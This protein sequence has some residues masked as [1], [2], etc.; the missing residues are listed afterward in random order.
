MAENHS[1]KHD[2][3]AAWRH[4][5]YRLY[6]L[7]WMFAL[8][9]TRIQSVAIA[10]EMYQRTGEALSLGLV[11]L[12]QALPTMTLAIPAGYLADRFDRRNLV[13][14]SL[15][16]MTFT[17]ASLALLSYAEGPTRLM[18]LILFLDAVLVTLG[19]P[20][21]MALLPQLVPRHVFPNAVTWNMSLMQITSVAGP[22]L[23]GF[24]ITIA[25]FP[26]YLISA[27][28]SLIFILLLTQL[29]F[30]PPTKTGGT[31]SLE[32]LFGGIK[33]V[34]KQRVIFAI[35]SLD[36][37]AVLLGGA[38]YLLPIYAEDILQ[39]GA[40]GYGWL[41]AAPAAGAFLVALSLAYLPPMKNAGRNLLLA[42]AGFGV[43]TIIFGVFGGLILGS[44]IVETIFS[45]P[46]IGRLVIMAFF[47][48]DYP[49]VQGPRGTDGVD[50]A[51]PKQG[52]GG[53]Q[54]PAQ[55]LD[56][57]KNLRLAEQLPTSF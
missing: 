57:R 25:I 47:T 10:W 8:L 38:V 46:G 36:L 41:Q 19:R 5:G 28:S 9:G 26:A 54:G 13:M 27:S 22:A 18:Y 55:A 39:V 48:R 16:G 45:W 53:A 2:P 49:V 29:K 51:A 14:I 3:Y 30:A 33:F 7:G 6:I 35:M 31:V 32:A 42:V 21:R 44:V 40:Q 56:R 12:A 17:S 23:G 4:P 43:V 1:D 34:W 50:I 52:A 24:V 15:I 11:G 20:A 37:F